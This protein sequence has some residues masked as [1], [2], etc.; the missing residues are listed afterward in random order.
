MVDLT[1]KDVCTLT[2]AITIPSKV[3]EQLLNHPTMMRYENSSAIADKL[4]IPIGTMT[5]LEPIEI[6]LDKF[7]NAHLRFFEMTFSRM[8]LN[9]KDGADDTSD[10]IVVTRNKHYK[11]HKQRLVDQLD[12]VPL[13]DFALTL[14]G[15]PLQE[16]QVYGL[17]RGLDMNI[18]FLIEKLDLLLTN[19]LT[20][21][22]E[23]TISLGLED[24]LP[25]FRENL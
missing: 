25:L 1:M 3:R 4:L 5:V 21:E 17:P 16:T 24:S 11:L 23:Q 15:K 9:Y 12:M 7:R 18:P 10:I 8:V 19:N 22:I 13:P 14:D 6:I 2:V 20:G